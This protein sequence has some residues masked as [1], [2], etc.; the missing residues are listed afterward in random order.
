MLWGIIMELKNYKRL[1]LLLGITTLLLGV[2]MA[3]FL[4]DGTSD[5]IELILFILIYGISIYVLIYYAISKTNSIKEFIKTYFDK[6][7][8]V[9]FLLLLDIL[10]KLSMSNGYSFMYLFA[11][12]LGISLL[13][14]FSLLLPKQLS[15]W[16]DIIFSLLYFTYVIGQDIYATIFTGLFSFKDSVNLNEGADFAEGVYTFKIMHILYGVILLTYLFLYL[17]HNNISHIKLSRKTVLPLIEIPVLLFICFNLNAVYPVKSARMHSSDHY[18]F[19]SNYDSSRLASRFGLVNLFYRDFGEFVL[20]SFKDKGDTEYIDNYFLETDKDHQ[21]NVYTGV[22]EGKN[23]IF[24]LAESYD[25]LA[26]SEELTPNLFKL[27]SEGLD[28]VNHFTPVYPRTTCDTEI[29]INTGLVPS[30]NDG[31]TCYEFNKNHY[32]NS[33]PS[34][35]NNS[36]YQTNAFHSNFSD[37]YTRN[38]VYEGF[39]YDVF[40]GQH[41]LSLTDTDIRY[42][43]TF[44]EMM[45]PYLYSEDNYF[46][47][48]ITLSGHSPYKDTNLAGKEHYDKVNN[49][50][51]D[52]IPESVKYYIATQIELD[53]M[54]KELFTQLEERNQ[55]EDTV[56][57]L[58]NDHYPYTLNQEDYESVTNIKDV[59]E[60]QKGAL[61]IW[62]PSLE[63]KEIDRVSSTFDLIPT[64][65][66]LL[67]LDVNYNEYVGND[68]FDETQTPLVLFKD[69]YVYD[70]ENYYDLKSEYTEIS[71]ELYNLA[72][73][74]Y[75]LSINVLKSDYYNRERE[76]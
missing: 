16:F 1:F 73:N 12:L 50:Y 14:I 4:K 2:R 72:D 57:I 62:N 52:T 43:S 65:A 13:V 33:L 49:Y 47:F 41:E 10:F 74:Y 36:G 46:N 71:D 76:Q 42:D 44:M 26:L 67:N 45:E 8:F 22:L 31:P 54:I 75:K 53:L 60:K 32:D 69:Y 56:I 5:I 11:L 30:I 24:I 15:K 7:L 61:Y 64:I 35:F 25:E 59:H 68:I 17:R 18:L 58:M 28:F 19:T 51:N 29:I 21:T 66:N 3:F 40:Y 37:F 23:V 63:H 39:Q 34:I 38:L 20:P 27:K 55:L 9:G 48:I 70:G 6:V